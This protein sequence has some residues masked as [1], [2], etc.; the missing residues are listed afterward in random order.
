[1]ERRKDTSFKGVKLPKDYLKLVADLFNKN[2]SK[3]LQKEKSTT[4]TFVAFGEL[5]PDEVIVA[6][7]LKYPGSLHMTT[8]YGSIDYPPA[9][10]T[11]PEPA[12]ESAGKD[13]VALLVEVSVNRCVDA[14]ASFFAAFFEEGR[15]MDYDLE[16]RQNWTPLELEKNKRVYLRINRD[17][18]E[19]DQ[20]ADALLNLADEEEQKRKLH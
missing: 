3:N 9:Q 15:P 11:K 8:C 16:Y 12:P 19:L 14:I 1:M 10:K 18:L 6:L 7:S 17:N 4:E 13:P 2:F 20:E 5:Y